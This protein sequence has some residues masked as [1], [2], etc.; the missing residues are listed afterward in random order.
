MY[1]GEF[2]DCIEMGPGNCGDSKQTVTKAFDFHSRSLQR[3]SSLDL[4]IEESIEH[5]QTKMT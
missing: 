2:V 3:A 1:H 4:H 5:D